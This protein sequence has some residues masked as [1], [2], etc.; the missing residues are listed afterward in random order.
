MHRS[1][2]QL[3]SGAH[4]LL[5]RTTRHFT[6]GLRRHCWQDLH[7]VEVG[8]NLFA[9]Q[10]YTQIVST[11]KCHHRW[12]VGKRPQQVQGYIH[13]FDITYI[14]MIGKMKQNQCL[15]RKNR[16]QICLLRLHWR[17]A[18]HHPIQWDSL[19][20]MIETM[21][22][23]KA[24]ICFSTWMMENRSCKICWRMG[25]LLDVAHPKLTTSC[26]KN[27]KICRQLWAVCDHHW[28]VNQQSDYITFQRW[29]TRSND[30]QNF[31]FYIDIFLISKN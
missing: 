20:I 26:G 10:L 15:L 3:W 16:R 25:G 2:S 18:S 31:K 30:E 13:P 23:S 28:R 5:A 29:G 17:S 1:P 22:F 24:D 21:N 4:Y 14:V 11:A 8:F 6:F 27:Q 7:Y 12:S 9:N 19:Q